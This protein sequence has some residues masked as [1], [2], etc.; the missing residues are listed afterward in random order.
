MWISS[1]ESELNNG[2]DRDA[3]SAASGSDSSPVIHNPNK[4]KPHPFH[5]MDVRLQNAYVNEIGDVESDNENDQEPKR[6]KF[7][8][9]TGL[10]CLLIN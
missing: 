7:S 8:K 3:N 9:E 4:D 10:I 6:R 1:T 2:E 5:V